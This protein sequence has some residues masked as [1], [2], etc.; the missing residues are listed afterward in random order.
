MKFLLVL[1]AVLAIVGLGQAYNLQ[2]LEN[3]SHDEE[4]QSIMDLVYR[5][6]DI[7]S[8]E[9]SYEEEL[10]VDK[11]LEDFVKLIPREK[12]I[13]IFKNYFKKDHK[14]RRGLK[15]LYT[16]RFHKL[17]RKVEALKEHQNVV[18]F[19]QKAGLNIIKAIKDFHKA[20]R[21]KDY[22]P[23]KIET[24]IEDE[25]EIEIQAIGDGMKGLFKDLAALLP[26]SEIYALYKEKMR[27][28]VFYEFVRQ[29]TTQKF[30]I[31][32]RNL[33]VHQTFRNMITQSA[34]RGLDFA[35]IEDYS[36]KVA[37]IPSPKL[38]KV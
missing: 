29:V 12:S 4:N 8:D 14:V 18:I 16:I 17:L 28:L 13:A 6:L 26:M 22:V 2:D 7:T 36:R 5:V 20:I 34:K 33:R 37:P 3:D 35:A 38:F 15:F 30:Q 31:L 25:S 10:T 27:N 9:S 11:E 24:E 21:M 23:P 32:V 1:L 19:L